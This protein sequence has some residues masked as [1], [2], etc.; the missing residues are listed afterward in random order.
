MLKRVFLEVDNKMT[1]SADLAPI[2]LGGPAQATLESQLEWLYQREP[3]FRLQYG[4][5]GVLLPTWF[6]NGIEETINTFSLDID[7]K[8]AVG[9]S[10]W[11]KSFTAH[12]FSGLAALRLKFN[13]VL[14]PR[15]EQ[16]SLD[17][18]DNGKLKRV[19]VAT[20][21]TFYCLANDPLAYTA[22]AKVVNSEQDLDQALTDLVRVIGQ[23]LAPTFKQLKVN[24]PQFWGAIGYA[25]GLV[26]QK[27]TQ[28]GIDSELSE[29]VQPVADAWLKS[30]LP[31]YAELNRVKTA[32]QGNIGIFYIRRETCC[33][34]YKL[35]GKKNC[36]TCQKREPLAQ[37]E[38]YQSKVPV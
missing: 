8:P 37:H 17:V 11:L 18:A 10:L 20:D 19:G 5:V 32:T 13:R 9:A 7:A 35:D 33:L 23:Y 30:V 29:K 25:L 3:F 38:L 27:L 24:T 4:S 12:L 28:H 26:F 21:C 2:W 6:E 1:L 34:K 31:D 15:F 14:V 16:I 36:A 22:Q